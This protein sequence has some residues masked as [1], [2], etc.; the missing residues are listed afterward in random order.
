MAHNSFLAKFPRHVLQK[1]IMAQLTVRNVTLFGWFLS[2]S[3][4]PQQ[5]LCHWPIA[6]AMDD[7]QEVFIENKDHARSIPFSGRRPFFAWFFFRVIHVSFRKKTTCRFSPVLCWV[8]TFRQL[9]VQVTSEGS[10]MQ[11]RPQEDF[12]YCSLPPGHS[13][14]AFNIGGISRETKAMLYIYI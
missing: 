3:N 13:K 5:H 1:N 6:L 7:L 11:R 9:Q 8:D 10:Q 4:R 2:W 14:T 12:L